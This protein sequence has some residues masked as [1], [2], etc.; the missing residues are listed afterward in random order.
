MPSVLFVSYLI[1]GLVRPWVSRRVRQQIEI[2]YEAAGT[3][4]DPITSDLS[5]TSENKDAV[6]PKD[7]PSRI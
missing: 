5:E 2:E 7:A 1:Y 3:P 4:E 6:L